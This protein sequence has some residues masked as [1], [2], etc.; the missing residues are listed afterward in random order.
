MAV[1]G[2]GTWIFPLGSNGWVAGISWLADR[3][4]PLESV[5]CI[6]TR[7]SVS[8]FG[9]CLTATSTLC[10]QV[11][12]RNSY[13]G[14][15]CLHIAAVTWRTTFVRLTFWLSA[16]AAIGARTNIKTAASCLIVFSPSAR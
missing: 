2:H 4:D 6:V 13:H 5:Y 3:E 12:P 7:K 9:S 10:R 1:G 16:L 15:S 11:C 14:A 8:P